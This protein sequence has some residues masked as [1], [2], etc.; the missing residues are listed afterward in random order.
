MRRPYLL[1]CVGFFSVLIS[2]C[3]SGGGSG[4][5]T[6]TASK[7]FTVSLSSGSTIAL[8]QGGTQTIQVSIVG[9]GGFSDPVAITVSG[10]PVGVNVSP[11]SLSVIPGASGNFTFSASGTAGLVRQT[12][13]LEAV[14]GAL[15]Q[16]LSLQINVNG[17]P[18]PDPFHLVGGTLTH[19]FYDPARQLL[20]AANPQLNEV[21]VIS[22]TDFTVHA[23]VPA[24]QPWSMDQMADNKTLVIGTASQEILTMD[25]DTLVVTQHPVVG[26]TP[27][28]IF[29][30]F[31]PTLTA[32]ANGKVLIIG[33]LQGVDSSDILDGGQSLVEWDS[34]A[35]TFQIIEPTH[36]QLTFEVDR[37]SRS[38][39]HKWA[40]FSADQFYLYSS[41][42]DTFTTTPLS[43]VNPPDNTFGVRGYAM[44]ADGTKIAVVSA[45][46]VTFLDRSFNQLGI[47]QIPRAFQTA[48]TLVAFSPDDSRLLLQ[49][50]LPTAIEL[51]DTVKFTAVGYLSADTT[52]P[53]P[54]AKLLG[55]DATGHSF[56]GTS[57]GFRVVDI[58]KPPI[59]N[60]ADSVLRGAFC[61]LPI[62]LG[63]PV[64]QTV[65]S[66]ILLPIPFQGTSYY[67]NGK[68]APLISNSTQI[69][70]PASSVAGPADIECIA[71]DGNT[72]VS[73]FAFSYGSDLIGISANLLPPTG[74]PTIQL[75]GYGLSNNPLIPPS[76]ITVGGKAALNVQSLGNFDFGA[77]QGYSAQ[78]AT[79]T[80]GQA[81][82]VT[83]NGPNGSSAL[84]NA[85]T[86]IPSA[87][88]I[89]AT[90]LLQ[91]L[92]D[93]HRNLLYALKTAEIDVFNPATL[94]FQSTIALPGSAGADVYSVMALSP[95]G[96]KLIAGSPNGYVAVLDPDNPA[97]VS[98]VTL[99]G[100][101]GFQSGSIAITK[102]NKALISGSPGIEVD[103]A[104]LSAQSIPT[105]QSNLL[106]ASA[107]G[108]FLYGADLNVTSG[109]VYK[110]DIAMYSSQTSQY[111]F[112]FWSDLAVSSDGSQ[113]AT[114]DGAPDA[115]GD[116]LGIFDPGLHLL[117]TNA[118][119]LVSLPIDVL[120]LGSTFGPQGKVLVVALGDSI[121]FWDA[122]NGRLRAR[123]A[124]P[125]RLHVFNFPEG[126]V[127]P[128]IA[129]DSTGQTIFAISQTGLTVM[130][131]PQPV[132]TLASQ[133]W[134][135]GQPP[136][137]LQKGNLSLSLKEKI[138]MMHGAEQ[139]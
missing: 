69:E 125:E 17:A 113:L 107:D 23:R 137:T 4:T 123:L 120:V 121:E 2:S 19:G 40:V 45:E 20:F 54:L 33:Q 83:V 12:G 132:D 122:A 98:V 116:I 136:I 1:F 82:G 81:V 109:K 44:N 134:A 41:D 78:L 124:S 58:T 62:T 99:P 96:T 70:L 48:R 63:V 85:A 34:V 6:T 74:N 128:Q 110:F 57:A 29:G 9:S 115:A 67:I 37:L 30:L 105:L 56:I 5:T 84:L 135:A 50:S 88:I 104:T 24:P 133:P 139:K 18:V 68:P 28:P 102:L 100:T 97:G 76:S 103:L 77:L 38:A 61:Q 108:N 75:Y 72:F 112:L 71:P 127:A 118:Y 47:A 52:P 3:G 95:D 80:P 106:R 14:S 90:G 64:N 65:Q 111:G 51:V 35:N 60:S 27:A 55:T 11:A 49:Y 86:Y 10:L 119:P 7:L 16:D 79:G 46:Q 25:E 42:A 93:S 114:I 138:S 39:D 8:S 87:T 26:L 89:P 36:G 101:P 59:P 94:Q 66:N 53:D 131:L 126:A 129:L 117:N 130:A 43:V 22:G 73:A 92:Y 15:K 91:I 21:D 32:L 13:T 31:F